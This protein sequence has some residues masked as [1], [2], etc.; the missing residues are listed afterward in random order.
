MGSPQEPTPEQYDE[1]EKAG[2][3]KMI[4]GP[5]KIRVRKGTATLDL[6]MPG[7]AVSFITLEWK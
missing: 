7:Q 3:L 6:S 1:L 2:K 4:R 5:V